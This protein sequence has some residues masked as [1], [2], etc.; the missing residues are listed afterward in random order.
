VIYD[1]PIL[2]AKQRDAAARDRPMPQPV[3][4][5]S[6][7]DDQAQFEGRPLPPRARSL[8]K[9][10]EGAGW[11]VR[12]CWSIMAIP[13]GFR[14]SSHHAVVTEGFLRYSVSVR[15]RAYGVAAYGLWREPGGFVGAAMRIGNA[16]PHVIGLNDLVNYVKGGDRL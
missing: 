14:E 3:V 12:A 4:L 7:L 11:S 10:A 1:N 2:A 8:M 16:W 9:A 13:A 6:S 5:V 15:L